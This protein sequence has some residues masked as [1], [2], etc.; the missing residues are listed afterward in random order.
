MLLFIIITI[1]YY[2]Y[3]YYCGCLFYYYFAYYYTGHVIIKKMDRHV[4]NNTASKLQNLKVR[5]LKPSLV[6][7]SYNKK[8]IHYYS[9]CYYYHI[10][11]T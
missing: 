2:H 4:F 1:F 6:R 11:M 5:E 9:Y 10:I 7:D 8:F 3:D